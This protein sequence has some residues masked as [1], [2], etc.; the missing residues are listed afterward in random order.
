MTYPKLRWFMAETKSKID[1]EPC[2]R[3]LL[4]VAFSL[5]LPFYNTCSIQ[6][7]YINSK[8]KTSRS[9]NSHPVNYLHQGEVGDEVPH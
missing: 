2:S 9:P 4:E 1:L 3:H 7:W 8:M 5:S 6:R